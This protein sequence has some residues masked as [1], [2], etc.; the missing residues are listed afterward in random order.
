[1]TSRPFTLPALSLFLLL[2]VGIS[3]HAQTTE[4]TPESPTPHASFKG[5]DCRT[6]PTRIALND[7]RDENAETRIVYLKNV[8]QQNDANEILVAVR[9]IADPS[10]KIYLLGSQ[11][12]II[13]RTYPQELAHLEALI[14]DLD[15]P[16]KLYRLT[17]TI[18]TIEDGKN[19]GTQHYSLVASEGQRTILKE[20]DK[21]PV[22]TGSYSTEKATAQTQFTYLDVGMN[23]DATPVAVAGGVSLKTK[24]EQSSIGPTNTIAGVAEPVVRQSVL[25]G[26]SVAQLGKPLMLGS[27]DI[28]NSTRH[29]DIDVLV[30]QVK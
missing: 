17:Y 3:A 13:L 1:M 12:A 15:Q 29:L 9:N 14:H 4:K 26:V 21:V 19:I 23:F 18:A 11:N 27:I 16:H 25:E 28:P 20:G 22:A 10:I 24:V 30:E 8:S 5:I 2:S 7:C 6:L